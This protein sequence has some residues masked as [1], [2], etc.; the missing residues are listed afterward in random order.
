MGQ[1]QSHIW[2]TVSSYMGKY[3]RI[4]SYIS[5]SPSSYM[6]LQLLHSEFPY[7]WGKFNFFFISAWRLSLQYSEVA[8]ANMLYICER[9]V[10]SNFFTMEYP[11]IPST[12]HQ[13]HCHPHTPPPPSPPHPMFVSCLHTVSFWKFWVTLRDDSHFALL[14]GWN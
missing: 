5:G 1:L 4:S 11:Y 3:L 12:D 13:I 9:F 8:A 6:T 14:N 10:K 2:L 7:I